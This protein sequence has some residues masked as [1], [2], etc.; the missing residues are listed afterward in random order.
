M[1]KLNAIK[2]SLASG[3]QTSSTLKLSDYLGQWTDLKG[4]EVKPKTLAG[5]R[6]I[7]DLYIIPHLGHVKLERV[8]TANVR[9]LL[10]AVRD[11]VSPDAANKAR[12][13]LNTAFRQ[14]V[15]DALIPRNP[16]T[17][18]KPYKVPQTVYKEWTAPEINRFLAAAKDHRLYAAFYL[19]LTTG[20]RHGELLGLRWQ[21]L[22]DD[23]LHIC[24]NLVSVKGQ[25]IST[26]KTESGTR[27]VLVDAET[28]E[29]LEQHRLQQATEQLACDTWGAPP[30]F[31]DLMFTTRE[32]KP[33]AQRNFDRIWY[34]LMDKAGVPHIRF[35]DL[36]H[37]HVSMLYR[38]GTDL[39]VISNRVGHKDPNFTRRQYN[40]LTKKQ[41]QT[42]VKP[43][44][45]LLQNP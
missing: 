40:H 34:R 9:A 36:R 8:T 6:Q 19:T 14:A 11:A 1:K 39:Q 37:T 31:D 23:T 7:I 18:T 15:H 25:N 29:L 32:G 20:L 12:K 44:S 45:A 21:D 41:K 33:L 43:L 2:T 5:Y 17:P 3:I 30:P 42:A 28:L 16:V 27:H 10:A 13:V 4:D 26:P 35:H 22:G 24:Q 38:A